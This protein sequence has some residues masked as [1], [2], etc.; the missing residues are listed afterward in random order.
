MRLKHDFKEDN[1]QRKETAKQYLQFINKLQGNHTI[2]LDAPWGS[3]KSKFIDFMCE[4][5][6]KDKNKDIYIKYNAWD[7]DYTDEPFLSLMSEI[8]SSFEEKKYIGKDELK[9]IK[10]KAIAISKAVGKGI[11]KGLVKNILG[12]DA[13][14]DLSDGIESLAKGAISETSQLL[15]DSTFKNMSQTKKTREQFTEELKNTTK[16]ILEEKSKNKLI[17]IIDELDR[18]KP[19]FAIELLEN[20]KHLFAIEEVIFFIAVDRTQLSESIKAVYGSGFDSDT[21]LDRFFDINLYLKKNN[22]QE[23]FKQKIIKYFNEDIPCV[24]DYF[25]YHKFCKEAI[26]ALELTLRDFEKI[27]SEAYLIYK[28]NSIRDFEL[29]VILFLLM[30]RKKSPQDYNTFIDHNNQ[31]ITQINIIV[32]KESNSNYAIFMRTYILSI[33]RDKNETLKTVAKLS[34]LTNTLIQIIEETKL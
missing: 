5:M 16:K 18:C 3:G 20:I 14:K 34:T 22:M 13:T 1:L 29:E 7:N 19:T 27:I 23:H 6:D 8:F 30:F 24:Y 31:N 26:E 32:F 15:I 11:T 2:A 21:Y 9:N 12:S 4:D 33:L 25:D 17:I 28:L 10:S